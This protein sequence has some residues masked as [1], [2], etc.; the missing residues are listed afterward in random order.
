MLARARSIT[1]SRSAASSE[2]FLLS[3][4]L[5]PCLRHAASQGAT[6]A[7]VARK[8]AKLHSLAEFARTTPGTLLL[9]VPKNPPSDPNSSADVSDVSAA[10]ADLLTQG[11]EILTWL[12]GIFSGRKETTNHKFVIGAYVYLDGEAHVRATAAA[13]MIQSEAVRRFGG[14]K[15]ALAQL[16]SPGALVVVVRFLFFS[17]S[18]LRFVR[19]CAVL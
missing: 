18:R 5:L 15:V 6:V 11:P 16:C 13:D 8:G 19:L 7:A 1:H 4:T 10:G 12:S 17:L 2:C 3:L 14:G 9:P